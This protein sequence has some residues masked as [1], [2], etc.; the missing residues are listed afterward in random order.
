M[1]AKDNNVIASNASALSNDNPLSI[2]GLSEA[3]L[4]GTAI[5]RSRELHQDLIAGES[6]WYMVT[7]NQK[8]KDAP[9]MDNYST[10]RNSLQAFSCRSVNSLYDQC[11]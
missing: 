9:K 7:G 6:G 8:K 11:I 1:I 2:P 5:A 10:Y 4:V 3:F